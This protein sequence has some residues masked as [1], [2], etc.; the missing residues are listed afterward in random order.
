MLDHTFHGAQFFRVAPEVPRFIVYGVLGVFLPSAI[1]LRWWINDFALGNPVWID[2][3]CVLVFISL[4]AALALMA[5][6]RLR[7]D[8]SGIA[9]RRLFRWDLWPWEAF[10]NGLIQK[11]DNLFTYKWPD[12]PWWRRR[13]TFAFLGEAECDALWKA[14]QRFCRP[15]LAIVSSH[16]PKRGPFHPRW[17]LGRPNP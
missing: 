16:R 17:S 3:L 7:V 6:W 2:Y 12:R 11:D 9:R 8:G 1:I 4:I 13:L 15:P 5:R 10:E 14:S